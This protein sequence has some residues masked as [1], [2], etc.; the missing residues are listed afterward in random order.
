MGGHLVDKNLRTM[1]H[2][3]Y[4]TGKRSRYLVMLK[5]P[6]PMRRRFHHY[7]GLQLVIE[8]IVIRAPNFRRLKILSWSKPDKARLANNNATSSGVRA[9][10]MMK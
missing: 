7:S 9:I 4:R 5:L 1:C 10:D 3:L 6:L 2:F 8:T